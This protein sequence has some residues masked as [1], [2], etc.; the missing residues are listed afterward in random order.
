VREIPLRRKTKKSRG[1]HRQHSKERDD[2][3]H[4]ETERLCLRS[5]TE[6]RSGHQ[7]KNRS[8][9]STVSDCPRALVRL[10]KEN[11]LRAWR[12]ARTHQDKGIKLTCGRSC[13]DKQPRRKLR[14]ELV[15]IG[16]GARTRAISKMAGGLRERGKLDSPRNNGGTHG[17]ELPDSLLT[18]WSEYS[19]GIVYCPKVSRVKWPSFDTTRGPANR[20]NCRDP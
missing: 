10:E 14:G 3:A 8:V 17:S 12:S 5:N 7:L 16:M 9:L 6:V 4:G 1:G 13:G 18:E 11:S 2:E 20:F 15:S 19:K